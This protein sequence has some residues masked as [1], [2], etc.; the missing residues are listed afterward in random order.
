[1]TWE[2]DPIMMLPSPGPGLHTLPL[3][4]E[5]SEVRSSSS[6]IRGPLQGLQLHEERVGRSSRLS[7]AQ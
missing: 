3:W 2:A 7:E 5:G 6:L 1:M 4:R